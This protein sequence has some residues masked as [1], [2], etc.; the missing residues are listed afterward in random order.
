M[1]MRLKLR[2]TG[3]DEAEV[4]MVT[5]LVTINLKDLALRAVRLF[6]RYL[7]CL[8]EKNN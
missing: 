2:R 7:A 3:T 6:R 8:P 1:V 4:L 5:S